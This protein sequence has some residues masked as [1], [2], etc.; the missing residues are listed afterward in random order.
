MGASLAVSAAAATATRDP[1]RGCREQASHAPLVKRQRGEEWSSRSW[2]FRKRGRMESINVACG[3]G[4]CGGWDGAWRYRWR[5]PMLW[6]ADVETAKDGRE[7]T[8]VWPR[9]RVQF[10]T[11]DWMQLQDC[12]QTSEP[13]IR[14]TRR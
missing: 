8:K 7:Q 2:C 13:W 3:P 12:P 4:V 6:V 14:K 5:R 9:C 11:K 10:L 1:L